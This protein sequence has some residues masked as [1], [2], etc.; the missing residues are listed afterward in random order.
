MSILIS[1]LSSRKEKMA[2]VLKAY[3]NAQF[4]LP[5]FEKNI[6]EVVIH[7]INPLLL[8]SIL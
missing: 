5:R 2:A 8:F 6:H 7:G 1:V 4:Y 3:A